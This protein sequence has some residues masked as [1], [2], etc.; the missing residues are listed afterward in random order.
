MLRGRADLVLPAG[1]DGPGAAAHR[2]EPEDMF[3]F[4]AREA[5][6]RALSGRPADREGFGAP[7]PRPSSPA[8]CARSS[9]PAR[10]PSGGVGLVVTGEPAVVR[11]V[12]FAHGWLATPQAGRA[13]PVL[14][15][16]TRLPGVT[17]G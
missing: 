13:Q 11:A 15:P 17:P 7:A 10:S 16:V 6:V 2:R 14:P 12:A 8:R 3:G 9:G 5:V 4:G 1:D